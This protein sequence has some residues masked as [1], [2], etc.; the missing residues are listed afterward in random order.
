MSVFRLKLPLLALA[1][2]GAGS[3]H[4]ATVLSEGFEN[5]SSL[6]TSGWVFTNNSTPVGTTSWFKPSDADQFAAQAGTATSYVA[7]NFN[8]SVDGGTVDNWLITPT[9]STA[10]A[11]T[12][13]VY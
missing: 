3:A 11:G 13:S 4:S 7:A 9:F 10:A 8:S 6:A 5:F 2:V 12:V 1:L